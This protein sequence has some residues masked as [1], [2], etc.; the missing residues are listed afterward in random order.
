LSEFFIYYKNN[1]V[2]CE[3]AKL[4]I[5]A[6][7]DKWVG[8]NVEDSPENLEDFR[9]EWPGAKTVPQITDVTDGAYISVGSYNDLVDYY[10]AS[11]LSEA[12]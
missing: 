12:T 8:L 10:A 5:E 4:L 9:A 7:G 1:C 2:Y 3:S 6:H 11:S